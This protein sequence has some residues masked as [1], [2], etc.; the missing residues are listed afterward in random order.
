M[1]QQAVSATLIKNSAKEIFSKKHI[2]KK[3]MQLGGLNDGYHAH[4]GSK[5]FQVPNQ[6]FARMLR[7]F[8][9]MLFS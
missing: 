9:P 1:S 8:R 5:L 2:G 7:L 3:Q 4:F 6:L